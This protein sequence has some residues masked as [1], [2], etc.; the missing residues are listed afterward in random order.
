MVEGLCANAEPAGLVSQAAHEELRGIILVELEA[1]LPVDAVVLG[2]HGSMVAHGHRRPGQL[3]RGSGG[4]QL[5]QCCG[6]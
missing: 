3:R 6:R 5:L 4:L 2:L 1:A